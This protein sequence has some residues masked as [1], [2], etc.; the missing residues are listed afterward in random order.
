MLRSMDDVIGAM[1]EIK[2]I[3]RFSFD[4]LIVT[5]TCVWV[6]DVANC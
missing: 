6:K 2:M 4:A 5:Y 1:F 3:A